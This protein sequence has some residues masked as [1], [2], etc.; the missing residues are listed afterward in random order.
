MRPP[1]RR[2]S[3]DDVA[4][5]TVV[6]GVLGDP[7]DDDRLDVTFR[8][9]EGRVRLTAGEHELGAWSIDEIAMVSGGQ[10][11][12]YFEAEGDRL[13]FVPSRP[14]AL[15]ASALVAP[16]EA[17]TRRERRAKQAATAT[18]PRRAESRSGPSN[19][20]P[21]TT[22]SA[23]RARASNDAMSASPGDAVPRRRTRSLPRIPRVTIRRR[24]P[25][26]S[27]AT[28]Q[29]RGTTGTGDRTDPPKESLWLRTVDAARRRGMF[30]LDRLPVDERTRHAAHAHTWTHPAA[31][32]SGPAQHICTICGAIRR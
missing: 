1:S 16:T 21:A 24:R 8:I 29:G 22:E 6:S 12:W 15:E 26:P 30:G 2:R 27:D 17:P 5:P 13:P 32:S 18:A 10:S 4:P 9:E 14:A 25:A 23:G 19:R 28:D 3:G 31:A 20:S 7:G 11:L